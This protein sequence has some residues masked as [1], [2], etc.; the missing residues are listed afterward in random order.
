MT[1]WWVVHSASECKQ[2]VWRSF[3]NV[4]QFNFFRKKIKVIA[5]GSKVEGQ[6]DIKSNSLLKDITSINYAM[7]RIQRFKLTFLIFKV[8]T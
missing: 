3:A 2:M 1:L 7:N 4:K 5:I 8:K 6:K